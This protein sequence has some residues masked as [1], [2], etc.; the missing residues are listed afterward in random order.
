MSQSSNHCENPIPCGQT[1]SHH[2]RQRQLS[3][4]NMTA[5]NKELLHLYR[6]LLR[7]C[8]TYPSKN[9]NKIYES[10]REDFR[11]NATLDP[12]SEKAKRQVH[13]AYKGLGQLH[14]F[15]GRGS[16]NFSVSLEQNPFPKPDGYVDK[17]TQHAEKV[18]QEESQK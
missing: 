14:Q 1:T 15:D 3:N 6:R 18:L 5:T 2:E 7:S 8:Q 10:I 4:D 12:A 16:P 17:K 11:E 13:I 9:R